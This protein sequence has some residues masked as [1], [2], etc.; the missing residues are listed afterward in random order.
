MKYGKGLNYLLG[1]EYMTSKFTINEE[2]VDLLKEI[3]TS[4]FLETV[5]E[6]GEKCEELIT[7][8]NAFNFVG[9]YDQ[10]IVWTGALRDSQ[11]IMLSEEEDNTIK[12][13]FD[14]SPAD[15]KTGY[16]YAYDVFVGFHTWNGRFI[17]GRPWPTRAIDVYQPIEKFGDKV[18]EKLKAN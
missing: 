10:D 3:L 11:T 7:D 5:K 8:P 17:P 2:G 9:V 6:L 4:S 16:H 18:G 15:P 1:E 14:W 12:A 13:T